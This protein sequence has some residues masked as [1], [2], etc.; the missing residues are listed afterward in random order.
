MKQNRKNLTIAVI[1]V[2]GAFVV[3]PASFGQIVQN[4]LYMGFQNS[5][6]G[7]TKDYIIN[8]G[9]ASGILGSSSVVTLSSDF[10]LSSFNT[11]LGSSTSMMGGVV[12]ASNGGS[13]SDVYL[14]QLRSGGAGTPSIPGSSVSA[15]LTRSED[16]ETFA[17]ISGLNNETAI[18][19]GTGVLDSGKTWESQVEPST[20]ASFLGV[21]GINPDSSVSKTAVL[22]ED[23]WY[24]SSSSVTG[25]KPF[26]YQGYFTLDLTGGSPKLTFTSTNVPGSSVSAPV[27]KSVTKSGGVVTLIWTTV[28]TH[29]YQLQYTASLA[30]TN[31][32]NIGSAILA[33]NTLMT[34]TDTPGA[35]TKRFYRV[36]AQ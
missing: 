29:N 23:L 12:G 7:G 31:W 11:V 20:G 9:P 19:A 21:T 22:Y 2:G 26:V 32:V 30:P 35:A 18:P 24:T 6:G 10:S 33:N 25:G 34:N 36:G 15:T 14:T 27:F 3:A 5:A 13:P 1:I 4:D 17:E 16:N 28:A 8:L